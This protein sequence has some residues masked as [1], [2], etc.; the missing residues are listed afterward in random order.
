MRFDVAVYWDFPGFEVTVVFDDLDEENARSLGLS[1]TALRL[2]R[3]RLWWLR[4]GSIWCPVDESSVRV[5]A[6]TQQA[7]ERRTSRNVAVGFMAHALG[8]ALSTAPMSW[9]LISAPW[10]ER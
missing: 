3:G 4:D 8:T 1:L 9:K 7:A 2:D 5:C 6:V 10:R